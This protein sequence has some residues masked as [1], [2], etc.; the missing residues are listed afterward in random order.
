MAVVAPVSPKHPPPP[1]TIV[2][3]GEED[4]EEEEEGEGEGRALEESGQKRGKPAAV[5][6]ESPPQPPQPQRRQ[7]Q[8]DEEGE[9]EESEGLKRVLAFM[10]M[11]RPQGPNVRF[12]PL[13]LFLF[14]LSVRFWSILT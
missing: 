5:A 9:E 14:G 1:A 11:C 6:A 2:E 12:F 3:E 8:R 13:I 7:Q 4:M 10:D